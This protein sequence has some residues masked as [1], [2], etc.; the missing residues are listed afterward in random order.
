MPQDLLH[1][2]DEGGRLVIPIGTRSSQ[3]LQRITR[4]GN[5]FETE[6]LDLVSFVPL[7]EGTEV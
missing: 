6:E 7:L 4:R 1:Q 2:L 3:Q 5:T